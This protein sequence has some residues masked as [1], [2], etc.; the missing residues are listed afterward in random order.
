M[1]LIS[2]LELGSLGFWQSSL[3]RIQFLGMKGQKLFLGKVKWEGIPPR[4][5]AT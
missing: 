2:F 3:S 1:L 4:E 5:D